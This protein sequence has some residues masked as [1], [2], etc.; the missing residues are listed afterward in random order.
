M[1]IYL[2]IYSINIVTINIATI[3]FTFFSLDYISVNLEQVLA[4]HGGG[5]MVHQN[6]PH[7]K[8]I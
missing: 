4:V 2:L 1:L 7:L 3:E 8:L 6:K 5:Y